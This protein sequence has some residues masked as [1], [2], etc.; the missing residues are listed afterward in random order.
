MSSNQIERERFHVHLGG[1]VIVLF[2]KLNASK[3]SAL[4][5]VLSAITLETTIQL[6]P[7]YRLWYY[8][9]SF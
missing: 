4:A 6:F 1:H 3:Y 7:V 9:S 8:D 5:L 2:L